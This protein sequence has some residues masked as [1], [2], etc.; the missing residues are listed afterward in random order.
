MT[1]QMI[2]KEAAGLANVVDDDPSFR[3]AM[4]RMLTAAGLSVRTHASPKYMETARWNVRRVLAV[5]SPAP[6]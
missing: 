4:S 1:E 2:A 3:T 6:P 5:N